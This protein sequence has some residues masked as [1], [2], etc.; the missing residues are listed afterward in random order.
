MAFEGAFTRLTS[1]AQDDRAPSLASPQGTAQPTQPTDGYS[2]PTDSYVHGLLAAAACLRIHHQQDQAADQAPPQPPV[3]PCTSAG[4][5]RAPP[6]APPTF[7]PS[8]N[9]PV[10]GARPFGP[11]TVYW[12][13]TAFFTTALPQQ[14][15]RLRRDFG[16]YIR[17]GNIGGQFPKRR[18]IRDAIDACYDELYD[19][20]P[21][22]LSDIV[23]EECDLSPLAAPQG[24]M[25]VA[26]KI[27]TVPDVNVPGCCRVDFFVYHANGEVVRHH[28]RCKSR[29]RDPRPD[30]MRNGCTLFEQRRAAFR[31]VGDSLHRQP[32]AWV[33][34]LNKPLASSRGCPLLDPIPAVRR[35]HMNEISMYDVMQVNSKRVLDILSGVDEGKCPLNLTDGNTFPWWVWMASAIQ[36]HEASQAGINE[37]WLVI[38]K[39]NK[40]LVY[41]GETGFGIISGEGKI[42]AITEAMYLA[43]LRR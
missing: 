7:S 25:V 40:R 13:K 3:A 21:L 12:A 22:A 31:G 19:F 38:E 10:P 37:V 35:V 5:D 16:D 8:L 11:P 41:D 9:A 17:R 4:S 2:Q 1:D 18:S 24:S 36:L 14:A 42:T 15:A 34:Q 43:L 28:P 26:E 32:P 29:L 27:P 33:E 30:R 20:L 39:K 6:P 23:S